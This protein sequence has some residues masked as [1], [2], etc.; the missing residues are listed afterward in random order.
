MAH[1]MFPSPALLHLLVVTGALLVTVGTSRAG[2]LVDLGDGRR[3][4]VDSYWNDGNQVHLVR[5]GVDL[6]LPVSRVRVLREVTTPGEYE[7][8]LV[9]P[10]MSDSSE[11]LEHPERD[12]EAED[13]RI[14]NHLLRVQRERFEARMRGDSPRT[15][16][17]LEREFRRTQQRHAEV[18]DAIERNE[19]VD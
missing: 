7:P 17:R 16:R 19:A 5:G 6:S 1:R 9:K 14:V 15:L 10:S 13:R 4:I 3:M 8:V 2:H 18:T 11:P 12:L